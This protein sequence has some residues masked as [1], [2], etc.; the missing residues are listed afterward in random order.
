MRGLQVSQSPAGV[1][2]PVL[3][4]QRPPA[5]FHHKRVIKFNTLSRHLC[6][7]PQVFVSFFSFF[8]AAVAPYGLMP[9]HLN[10]T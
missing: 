10:L 6:C 8:F 5:A 9:R 3:H 4:A 7:L 1:A 2:V